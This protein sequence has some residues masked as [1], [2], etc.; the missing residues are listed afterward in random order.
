MLTSHA[1]GVIPTGSYDL[2]SIRQGHLQK[3]KLGEQF[4][5]KNDKDR[6]MELDAKYG[7]MLR[8]LSVTDEDPLHVNTP[9]SAGLYMCAALLILGHYNSTI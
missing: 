1:W 4:G 3:V 5:S 8:R 7:F 6:K 9:R 2:T